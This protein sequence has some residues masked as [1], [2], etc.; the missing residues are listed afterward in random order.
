MGPIIEPKKYLWKTRIKENQMQ[1]AQRIAACS[2][3][4][5]GR[6]QRLNRFMR[7][8]KEK[9]KQHERIKGSTRGTTQ[10]ICK[11]SKTQLNVNTSFQNNNHRRLKPLRRDSISP[12]SKDLP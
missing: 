5:N 1:G 6:D 10:S 9:I 7:K 8:A 3:L 12:I 2:K 11:E 4:I